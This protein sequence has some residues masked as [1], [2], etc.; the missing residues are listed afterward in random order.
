MY[1]SLE[2]N[3]AM[4]SKINTIGLTIWGYKQGCKVLASQG[5]NFQAQEVRDRLKDISA[6]IRI[7]TPRVDFYTLQFTQNYK[8]Y[9]QYRSSKEVN[10]QSGVFIAISLY[11]PH[12]LQWRGVRL[13]LNLL[14]DMYFAEHIDYQT[15]M[16]QLNV[17]EDIYPYFNLLRSYERQLIDDPEARSCV[18]QLPYSPKVFTYRDLY[19]VDK[20]FNMPYQPEFS[21]VQDVVFLRK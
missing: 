13:V 8:I 6:F 19:E 1:L 16:P 5:V 3:S 11:I 2:T 18:L 10:G 7:H 14:M 15:N 17:K 20:Y 4:D 12:F 9:T 21:D